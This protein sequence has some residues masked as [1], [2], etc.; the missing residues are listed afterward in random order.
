MC[1]DCIVAVIF[2]GNMKHSAARHILASYPKRE[3][4]SLVSAMTVQLIGDST[5]SFPCDLQKSL[6]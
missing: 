3:N 1:Y 4:E 5:T 2:G 6:I